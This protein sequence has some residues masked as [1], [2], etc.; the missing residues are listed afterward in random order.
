MTQGIVI[1]QRFGGG[2]VAYILQPGDPGYVAG[3]TH[4]LIAAEADQTPVSGG[5]GVCWPCPIF[6]EVAVPGAVGT[7]IG[8]GS[9]N[10]TAII[11]QSEEGDSAA[12]EEDQNDYAALI[13]RAYRGGGFSDWY[14]PSKDELYQLF[15]NRAVIGGFWQR[16]WGGVGFYWSSSQSAAKASRAWYQ[17]FEG[18]PSQS[19]IS[20][21]AYPLR[22]RAVRS[23]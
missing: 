2:V 13:A 18:V 23:F 1:G 14:L 11:A 9:A 10:T 16:Y 19:G 12:G 3:K 5:G 4:G 21:K 17:S 8:S 15:V 7:A 20:F 6:F 22:V